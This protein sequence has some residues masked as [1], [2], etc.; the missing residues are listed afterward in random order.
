MTINMGKR[1]LV[2][3]LLMQSL[4]LKVLEII[5]KGIKGMLDK[6]DTMV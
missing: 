2:L 5:L 4:D 1:I 3:L 6:I